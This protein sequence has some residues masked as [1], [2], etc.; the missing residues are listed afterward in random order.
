MNKKKAEIS[1]EPEEFEPST[2]HTDG[3]GNRQR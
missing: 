1:M 2:L 3:I